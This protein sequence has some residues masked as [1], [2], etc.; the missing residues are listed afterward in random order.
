MIHKTGEHQ[1]KYIIHIFSR[2]MTMSLNNF[3]RQQNVVFTY[4][5]YV[6]HMFYT[7][8]YYI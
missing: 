5:I 4:P 8:A 6:F 1:E 3:S 2:C 7:V